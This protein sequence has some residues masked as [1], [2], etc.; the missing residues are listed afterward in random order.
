MF[1][2]DTTFGTERL[3][4]LSDGVFAIIL[5]L[6]VLDLKLPELPDAYAERQMIHALEDRIPNLVA[7]IISFILVAR[8]W[9]VHHSIVANLARCH[10]GTFAWNFI[11]LGTCSLVPFGAGLIGTYEW[12]PLAITLF[13]SIFGL[14]G[15]TLGLFARHAA[16]ETQL[17]HERSAPAT[18]LR[19]WRYHAVVIPLVAA[20]SISFIFVAKIVSL[21]VWLIEPPIA[22]ASERRR[23]DT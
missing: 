11:L 14:C 10:A 20:I 12:D 5:T 6:L 21:A 9:I 22:I 16:V 13:S 17:H 3:G 15:V 7:W 2:R 8:I 1:R 4:A 19:Q 18:L 23:T